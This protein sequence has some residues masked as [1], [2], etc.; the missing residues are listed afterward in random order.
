[1]IYPPGQ[2]KSGQQ[3]MA[4][5]RDYLERYADKEGDAEGQSIVGAYHTVY[6]LDLFS[7]ILDRENRYQQ[8]IDHRNTIFREA[9]SQANEFSDCLLIATFAIYNC[10]NTLSHQC[11]EANNSAAALINKVDE[12]VHLGAKS[13]IQIDKSAAALRASFA[14]VGLIT[15]S[16]DQKQSMTQ[17]IRQVE[18]RFASASNA[19]SSDWERLLNAL[20]RIVEML[21]IFAFL[22]DRDL[23]D[24]VNQIASRFQEEDQER[25]LSLKLRN[26]FC[27]FFELSHLIITHV[28]SMLE[29]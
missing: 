3:L 28:D 16:L 21:Q 25:N 23:K 22:T 2:G 6:V 14:L 24:Q 19:A 20:Y 8:L 1:M 11:T 17:V 9:S 15:I 13:G 7:R 18:E 5:W 29:S 10:L 12:Q 26:G 27:R 4:L